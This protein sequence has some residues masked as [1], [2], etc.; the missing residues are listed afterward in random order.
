[1]NDTRQIFPI[2]FDIEAIDFESEG[3]KQALLS[4]PLGISP[5][6]VATTPELFTFLNSIGSNNISHEEVAN[7]LKDEDLTKM[8]FDAVDFLDENYYLLSPRFFNRMNEVKL[9]YAKLPE[10]PMLT[11]GISYPEDSDEFNNFAFDLFDLADESPTINSIK[12]LILPHID[13]NIGR[14]SQDVYARALNSIKDTDAELFVIFGTSHRISTDYFMLSEKKYATP[15]G[16]IDI[17]NELFENLITRLGDEVTIDDFTHKFEHSIEFQAVLLKYL[18]PNK[19]IKILPI[20]VGTFYGLFASGKSPS[21][22]SRITNFFEALK[23]E[24]VKLGRKTMFISS[25]D[26]SHIGRKFGDDFDA[27]EKFDDIKK[28]DMELIRLIEKAQN[29]KFIQSISENCDQWRVCGASPIY[30]LMNTLD[31]EK[32]VLIDYSIWDEQSTKS[33]VSFA[34]IALI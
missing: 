18:F 6:S 5:Q 11:A 1:M 15:L 33:A 12:G 16:P 29:K 17:D 28:S 34:S 20:L 19:N 9:E 10:R 23:E 32:G 2:R 27:E 3:I 24:I 4:D 21:E 14:K 13:F 8:V 26:F 7:E 25:A 22:E 31:Y 30:A